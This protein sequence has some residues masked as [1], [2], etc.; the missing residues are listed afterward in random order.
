M[1]DHGHLAASASQECPA[2]TAPSESSSAADPAEHPR[3]ND[4]TLSERT[5]HRTC[6]RAHLL[7]QAARLRFIRGLLAAEETE[8]YVKLGFPTVHEYAKDQFQCNC[9]FPPRSPQGDGEVHRAIEEN[10]RT[11]RGD[12]YGLRN[13]TVRV[14]FK[15]TIEEQDRVFKAFH[16]LARELA[17][18]VKGRRL[19]P[20]EI[21]LFLIQ[22]LLETDP[23]G[24][25][26]GRVE[27]E[28]SLCTFLY[29]LCRNCNS[30]HLMTRDGPVEVPM[31]VIDRVK[32]SALEVELCFPPSIPPRGRPAP[33][34]NGRSWSR[35][36][37]AR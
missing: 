22:R 9:A 16:K 25:P 10:R 17:P 7:G 2:P 1:C 37:S 28:E 11:P 30:A 15:L 31:E 13:R 8:L 12:G 6:W 36:R 21:F 26:K 3:L 20:K 24:T 35:M 32:G 18:S 19:E 34:R 5:I 14:V 33:K 29:H 4:L 23:A 27:K